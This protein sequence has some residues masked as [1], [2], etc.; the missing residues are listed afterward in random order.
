MVGVSCCSFIDAMQHIEAASGSNSCKNN[1]ELVFRLKW[2]AGQPIRAPRHRLSE[3][4]R[5]EIRPHASSL[6]A[7]LINTLRLISLFVYLTFP[8]LSLQ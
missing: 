1:P 2:R 4:Y 6:R 3:S 5:K 8:R 7:P